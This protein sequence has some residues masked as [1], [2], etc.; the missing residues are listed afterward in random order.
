MVGDTIIQYYMREKPT[1]ELTGGMY[2]VHLI[3]HY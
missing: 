3:A 1:Q 2:V